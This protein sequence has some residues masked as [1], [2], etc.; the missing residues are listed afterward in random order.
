[1]A[2]RRN[3]NKAF[4]M[5][6]TRFMSI[7]AISLTLFTLGVVGL[8]QLSKMSVFRNLEERI[9]YRFYLPEGNSD[10]DNLTL[11]NKIKSKRYINSASILTTDSMAKI[12]SDKIGDNPVDVLGYNP[13]NP[14]VCINLKE[15]Y[16]DSLDIIEKDLKTIISDVKLDYREDQLSSVKKGLGNISH[17]LEIIIV[18]QL[19][20]TFV[21]ISNTTKLLIHSKR[22]QIRTL[23][24]VGATKYFISKPIV[25]RSVADG[26]TGAV[27]SIAI[28]SGLIY[29]IDEFWNINLYDVISVQY[30]LLLYVALVL[31]STIISL[32]SSLYTS[33]RY[34]RMDGGKINLI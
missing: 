22:M 13:F 5:A 4:I 10:S 32:I 26:I 31:V 8:L 15:G 9:E 2:G 33:N 18:L 7:I 20:V 3:K 25:L 28:L 23:S 11:V 29:V 30:V 27:I 19:I 12:V 6:G 34:V 17:I 21:Q 14:M 24:L 16:L 1:M